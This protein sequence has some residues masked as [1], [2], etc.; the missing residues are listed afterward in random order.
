MADSDLAQKAWASLQDVGAMLRAR[1][2]L[3]SAQTLGEKVRIWGSPVVWSFGELVVGDRVRIVS[4]PIPTELNVGKGGRLEIGSGSYINYGCSIGAT[5]LIRIGPRCNIGSHVIMMD[6]DFH[7]ME[8]ERRDEL[9]PSAPIVLEEN[10]WLG[11]RAIILR[12]VTVGAG[13][14]VAAGS[15]VSKNVPTRVLVGGVPARVIREL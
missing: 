5:Q 11:V 12:G 4:R 8:P 13:S 3:K 7:R 1:W 2:H 15:I 10:V 6:N 14:V 9:P